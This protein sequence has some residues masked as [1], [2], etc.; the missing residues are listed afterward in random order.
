MG[1]ETMSFLGV[2]RAIHAVRIELARLNAS[3]PDVPHVPCAMVIGVQ[4]DGP[5]GS[6]VL[7]VVEE[8]EPDAGRVTA[9]K[10]EIGAVAPLV[11][12]QG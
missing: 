9:E 4:L 5:G 1:V 12:T 8:L 7:R 3:N 2:V 6:A 10:C 11:G